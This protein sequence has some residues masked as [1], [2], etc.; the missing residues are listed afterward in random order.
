MKRLLYLIPLLLLSSFMFVTP[1]NALTSK[2]L[3][4]LRP[5]SGRNG[6]CINPDCY[7]G[8]IS[9]KGNVFG[10]KTSVAVSDPNLTNWTYEYHREL[11]LDDTG[12][13]E[14]GGSQA[15][16]VAGID[17][18]GLGG[19]SS[20]GCGSGGE[21][22]QTKWFYVN[23]T[24]ADGI[25]GTQCF[26]I[27]QTDANRLTSISVYDY[28][29]ITGHNGN[30]VQ[31]NTGLDVFTADFDSVS[32]CG[33]YGTSSCGVQVDPDYYEIHLFEKTHA[34][35]TGS[36][37][38]GVDW[39]DNYYMTIYRGTTWT[40]QSQSP[41]VCNAIGGTQNGCQIGS[42]TD[43]TT[44]LWYWNDLPWQT[45]YGGDMYDCTY[46]NYPYNNTFKVYYCN[47]GGGA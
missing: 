22:M 7:N 41:T 5:L 34:V 2:S 13:G 27:P 10:A 32:G 33:I 45:P 1:A 4:V 42:L 44:P 23:F 31:F 35:F 29:D 26:I 47:L 28:L 17:K 46:Q 9:W 25:L 3:S 30:E 43:P 38:W 21:L 24:S 39:T 14:S 8:T 36:L 15:K 18:V 20:V 19:R 11:I 40:P 37:I 16:V 6:T 12:S